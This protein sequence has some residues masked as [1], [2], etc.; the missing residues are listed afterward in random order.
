M[1]R[2][3]HSGPAR[4][5]AFLRCMLGVSFEDVS[6]RDLASAINAVG[7]VKDGIAKSIGG[8]PMRKAV[9]AQLT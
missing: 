9:P 2:R 5:Q 7:W 8:G 4:V 3:A 1:E 6:D